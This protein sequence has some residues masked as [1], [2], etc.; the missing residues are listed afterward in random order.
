MQASGCWAWWPDEQPRPIYRLKDRCLIQYNQYE[1]WIGSDGQERSSRNTPI[2]AP[3]FL[4]Q[5]RV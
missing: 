4:R 3:G 2:H 1:R 5:G